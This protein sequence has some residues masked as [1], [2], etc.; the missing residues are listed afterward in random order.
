MYKV[1]YQKYF[2]NKGK[3]K[4]MNKKPK[5]PKS[6]VISFRL[7]PVVI[8]KAIDGL[9][10]YDKS[11][12]ITKLSS[13]IKQTTLYGI[14]YLTHALPFEPSK[15][16]QVIVHNLTTQGNTG[17]SIE[18][19]I[20]G[21]PLKDIIINTAKPKTEETSYFDVIAKENTKSAKSNV[22]DFSIPKELLEKAETEEKDKS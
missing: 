13:I 21:Q 17:V 18:Q 5:N 12:D 6:I 2:V 20:L 4:N 11:T 7:S 16:S 10:E 19:S 9:K 1:R 15:E 14:N 22:T 8:A 3:K